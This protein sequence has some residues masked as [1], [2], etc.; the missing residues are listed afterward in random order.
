[1]IRPSFLGED[2][3]EQSPDRPT[4]QRPHRSSSDQRTGTTM[5]CLVS[6][7]TKPIEEESTEE[8]GDHR[9]DHRP[10]DPVSAPIGGRRPGRDV[11]RCSVGNSWVE[12]KLRGSSEAGRM[13]LQR[14]TKL[15]VPNRGL[16]KNKGNE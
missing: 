9:P 13:G 8:T 12:W 2:P 5:M 11:E 6:C 1:M 14:A 16:T 7:L 15:R 4:N 10:V 3:T